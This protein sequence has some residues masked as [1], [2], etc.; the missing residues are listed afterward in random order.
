MVIWFILQGILT[1][2]LFMTYI[3]NSGYSGGEVGM[4]PSAVILAVFIQF[5]PSVIVFYILKRYLTGQR[6]VLFLII[7]M[8]L[9]ELAYL[10]FTDRIPILHFSEKGLLGFLNRGYSLSSILSGIIIMVAFLIVS[11]RKSK[12]SKL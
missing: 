4:A 5:L 8:F 3:A 1:I 10:F 11:L 12:I 9:Y 6:R 2:S 7:N